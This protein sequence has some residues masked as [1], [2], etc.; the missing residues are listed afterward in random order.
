MIIL[1][2][3]V[4]IE[5]MDRNSEH[6]DLDFPAFPFDSKDAELS[7]RIE[8]GLEAKGLMVRSMDAMLAAIVI[9]RAARLYTYNIK[10]FERMKEFGLE[11][12]A[13]E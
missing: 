13:A 5:I 11:L 8:V 4:L 12:F 2:T 9:R 6:G 10:H 3:D 1:D 7:S